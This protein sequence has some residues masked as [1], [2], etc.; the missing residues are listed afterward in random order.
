MKS[1]PVTHAM[2]VQDILVLE[3]H[4]AEEDIKIAPDAQASVWA[5]VYAMA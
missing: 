3:R 5:V 2:E 1:R 4:V